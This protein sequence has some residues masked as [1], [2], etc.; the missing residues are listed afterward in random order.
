MKPLSLIIV[1]LREL[2]ATLF[3]P[4][5]SVLAIIGRFYVAW[6][7]FA[8]G[9]TKIDDW[10]TTLFLFEYEY[11]VPVLPFVLSAYLATIAELFLPVLLALGFVSRISALGLG[12]VN[13]V[14]V[15]SL[16][17][18]AAAALYGHIIWG[19]ILLHITVWGAG[20]LSLDYFTFGRVHSQDAQP[21]LATA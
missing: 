9:L 2:S 16:E 18:I 8:S 10:E 21:R 4:L 5:Q 17:D 6:V 1:R 20:K 13:I 7:F 19:L 3:L 14:A 12:I 15:I 11:H